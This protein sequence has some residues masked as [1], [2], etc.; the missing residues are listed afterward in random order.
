[1]FNTQA[2]IHV[3]KQHTHSQ[4]DTVIL[5]NIRCEPGSAVH[6]S[7]YRL[8]NLRWYFIEICNYVFALLKSMF[9]KVTSAERWDV[10]EH[11]YPGKYLEVAEVMW[12]TKTQ[13]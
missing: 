4:V 11:F 6:M 1:M 7:E 10:S 2:F 8:E 12:C 5:I 13:Y 9:T 3:K